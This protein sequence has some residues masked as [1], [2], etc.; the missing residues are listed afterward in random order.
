MQVIF[1]YFLKVF[2]K[3]EGQKVS[4]VFIPI[5]TIILSAKAC[6]GSESKTVPWYIIRSTR[7]LHCVALFLT[8]WQHLL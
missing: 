3:S 1:Y 7:L 8:V 6:S 4:P 2:T 5:L